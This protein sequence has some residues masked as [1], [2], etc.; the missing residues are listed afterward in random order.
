MPPPGNQRKNGPKPA[1]RPQQAATQKPPNKT[2]QQKVS[3][4]NATAQQ[5]KTAQSKKTIE[6]STDSESEAK[7]PVPKKAAQS[8][9]QPKPQSKPQ[10]KS[11]ASQKAIVHQRKGTTKVVEKSSEK[12][13]ESSTNSSSASSESD[14][15]SSSDSSASV[16]SSDK[17]VVAQIVRRKSQTKSTPATTESEKEEEEEEEEEDEDEEDTPRKHITRSSSV[18]TKRGSLLG[19][20]KGTESD[21]ENNGKVRRGAR[22]GGP[23]KPAGPPSKSGARAKTKKPIPLDILENIPLPPIENRKCPVEGCDSTGHLGG[24]Y[25]KHFS[26][27]A[28]PVFHNITKEESKMNRQIRE[29]E[30]KER[31]KATQ[32][33]GNKSPRNGPNSEQRNYCNKI[34]DSRDKLSEPR[35]GEDEMADRDRQPS[36]RGFTPEWD[37]KLFLEAQSAASEKIEDDLRGLPDTK[38]IRYIE[39]G[40]YEMEAWYQSQ[41]PDDYN[42]QPK[43]YICEFCLKYMR[44]KTILSRHAAKCVW[45][46]PPGD[47]IYRKD[48]L[49]V[50]EV[51]GKKYKIYCQNLCLLAMLF[52]DHKTLY[53]D[54][55]PFLFYIMTQ[56]DGEGCHIIGY[57][58]KEKNSFLNYNVSCIMT[59]PPYQRQGYGRLLIDFSY[60]LTKNEGKIGS[61]EKPLSDLGLISYRSYWKDLLL[62]YLATYSE[63]NVYIKDMSTEMA[64][65]SY[66]IVSTFQAMGMMKYWKGK[67]IL[68]R[69]QDLLEEFLERQKRR[70]ADYKEIDPKCLNWRP[71]VP[72]PPSEDQA[73]SNKNKAAAANKA[74]ADRKKAAAAASSQ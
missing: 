44:S 56:A 33:V 43:I 27:E 74:A 54:V 31:E 2:Q 46:H 45:K 61:P 14:S 70:R 29:A 26:V 71:Y 9:S 53:Y 40:R 17:P 10:P 1:A 67:H 4:S 21:S 30:M 38:G 25:E 7:K 5:K 64:V 42:Q 66:D 18:R 48:K 8:K 69:R 28:C 3:G 12:S 52:L 36:L 41:Y 58:S 23:K 13:S 19:I 49:S 34:R 60:L 57:F 11:T 24:L 55:E 47:E 35:P 22:N 68:L 73:S 65:S 62:S 63:K 15:D 6:N 51:D 20:Q 50:W 16:K 37:L 32:A 72:P 39:M 59:L